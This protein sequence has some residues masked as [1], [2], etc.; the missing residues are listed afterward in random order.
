MGYSKSAIYKQIP[1]NPGHMRADDYKEHV[2]GKRQ[3][4]V[5]ADT[6]TAPSGK[7]RNV[8]ATWHRPDGSHHLDK[9]L[10]SIKNEKDA[11]NERQWSFLQAFVQR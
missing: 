10:A 4:K 2:V 6:F 7:E 3:A 11:P 5:A 9:V 1:R 8:S